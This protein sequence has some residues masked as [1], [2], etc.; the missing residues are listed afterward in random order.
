MSPTKLEILLVLEVL[1]KSYPR[2]DNLPAKRWD[3]KLFLGM[4]ILNKQGLKVMTVMQRRRRGRRSN[5]DLDL[6]LDLEAEVQIGTQQM[7]NKHLE[8][9]TRSRSTYRALP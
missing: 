6:D 4:G 7:P 9:K 1:V 3:F 5:M 8:V 2:Y